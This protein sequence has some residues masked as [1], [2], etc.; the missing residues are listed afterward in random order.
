MR[1]SSAVNDRFRPGAEH[2]ADPGAAPGRD[3]LQLVA[4]RLLQQAVD[5]DLIRS[6]NSSAADIRGRQ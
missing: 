6:R 1:R 3:G 4:N 2:V 5:T